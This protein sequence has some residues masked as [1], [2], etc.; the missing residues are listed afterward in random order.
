MTRHIAWSTV[1]QRRVEFPYISSYLAFRELPVLLDLLAQVRAAGHE[2]DLLLVDGGGI[3]HPR[4]MGLATMLGIAADVATVG[5]TK[6]LLSGAVDL[7]DLHFGEE[8]PIRDAQQHKVGIAT[9]AWPRSRKPIFVSPGH[10]ISVQQ[11]VR[12]VRGQLGARRLP[13]PVYWADQLS[14]RA[15]AALPPPRLPR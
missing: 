9:L 13:D 10:R 7:Q 4:R 1:T 8:R 14:R 2:P 5:V 11:A 12:L 3:A 15:A 6:K